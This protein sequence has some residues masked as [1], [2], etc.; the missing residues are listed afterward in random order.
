MFERET[1]LN[2][3]SIG[4]LEQLA[5]DV[6]DQDLISRPS[7]A[8]HTPLWILGHLAI[9]GE[10]GQQM[11]GGRITHREWIPRFAPG[12]KDE[13]ASAESFSCA[14]LMSCLKTAYAEL[15]RMAAAADEQVLNEPHRIELLSDTLLKTVGDVVAHL[16][17]THFSFHVSQLSAWRQASGHRYLL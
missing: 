1:L 11:L 8:L 6:R 7:G 3:F 12:T 10:M 4:Y 13:F 16:L 17:T 14:E 15:R 5:A 2:E 9:C